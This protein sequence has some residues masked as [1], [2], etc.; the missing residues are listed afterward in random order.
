MTG[1]AWASGRRM[2]HATFAGPDLDALSAPFRR[3]GFDVRYGGAH[4][5]GVTHMAVVPFADGSYLELIS[6]LEP[7]AESPLWDLAIRDAA[8][9]CAWCLEAPDLRAEAARVRGL[10][11][12]VE[13]PVPLSR[14]TP[15]GETAS[16]SLAFPGEGSPGSLLPFLIED[17]TPRRVRLASE[18]DSPLAGI[19]GVVVGVSDLDAAAELFERVYGWRSGKAGRSEALGAQIVHLGASPVWLAA[20]GAPGSRLEERLRRYGTLPCAF[21]LRAHPDRPL[22]LTLASSLGDP[23]GWAGNT[24]RW[25]EPRV[26]D[27]PVLGLCTDAGF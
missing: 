10:G 25:W 7:G 6:T 14:L 23:E 16:W 21:L 9:P 8:G 13:G 27:G 19:E 12:P 11:V 15:E 17:A 24:V 20:P 5:N 22:P 3:L 18:E 26:L 2:D 4:S 1:E